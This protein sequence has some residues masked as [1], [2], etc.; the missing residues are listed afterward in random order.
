MNI[1][2]MDSSAGEQLLP[3]ASRLLNGAAK[4][5][6]P[7]D[8]SESDTT[9]IIL[10]LKQKHAE[11]DA[12]GLGS[13]ELDAFQ[14]TLSPFLVAAASGLGEEALASESSQAGAGD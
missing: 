14:R 11:A 10:Q 12:A 3:L 4:E 6:V 7:S 5:P 1:L 8:R 9:R 13:P 2:D